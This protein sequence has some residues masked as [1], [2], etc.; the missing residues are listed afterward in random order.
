MFFRTT[1]AFDVD[2]IFSRITKDLFQLPLKPLKIHDKE[3]GNIP[4]ITNDALDDSHIKWGHLIALLVFAG[5]VAVRSVEC[6]ST[7]IVDE[8]VSWVTN[9]FDTELSHWLAKQEG[10]V[11]FCLFFVFIKTKDSIII[12]LFYILNL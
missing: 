6:Q 2:H 4:T 3:N 8:I 1:T 5:L 7:G 9:F 11:S 12:C 10:W